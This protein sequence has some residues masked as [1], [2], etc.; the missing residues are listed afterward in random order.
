MI[1]REQHLPEREPDARP[2]R[3]A[4]HARAVLWRPPRWRMKYTRDQHREH[5]DREHAV[6]G[7]LAEAE[8][9]EAE[10]VDL[11]REDVGGVLRSAAGQHPDHVEIVE[12]ED[13]GQHEV[14]D[15]HLAHRR[16]DD[17][18]QPPH[19]P[20][21][22]DDRRLD[23]LA[24]DVLERGEDR[25]R[26]R[27][28]SPSTPRRRSPPPSRSR[29]RRA[30]RRPGRRAPM[31]I[32][33]ELISPSCGSYMKRHRIA[34]TTPGRTQGRST[35]ERIRPLVGRRWLRSSATRK[36]MTFWRRTTKT[37]Q[38]IEFQTIWPK[39]PLAKICR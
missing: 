9:A 12:G 25:P 35:S 34:A 27:T 10:L 24:V 15:D 38:T 4:A 5:Q 14:D 11:G 36:P 3:L 19:R 20:G 37:V 18:E 21:A 13:R 22:V 23:L 8:L 29:I 16:D 17:A 1:D 7:R 32:R 30:R 6:G 33:N 26:P 31:R 2:G 28:G 39:S